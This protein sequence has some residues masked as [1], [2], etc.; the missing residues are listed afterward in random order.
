MKDITSLIQYFKGDELASKVWLDKYAL[1]DSN[2]NV[3]E[4]SPQQMH[5]R[6]AKEFARI[7]AKYGGKRAL[8]EDKILK[9]FNNFKYIIPGG[10]VMAVLGSSMIGSLSNCFVIGQPEDSYSGIM[11]LREEQAHLMKRRAGVGKDLSTLRPSGATVKNAA[12]TSTGAASFMDV[13]SA[14]TQEVAQRGR[15]GALMLTLDVRHPDI[16]D[17]IKKKQDL[18][19]VTGANISVKVTDDFMKAV[20]NDEDYILRWPLDQEKEI[21]EWI[22]QSNIQ[23]KSAPY[24]CLVEKHHKDNVRKTVTHVYLKKV[25]AKELWNLLIHCAWNTAEPGI[26]FSDKHIRFSPDGAYPQYRGVSTNPCFRGDMKLLTSTGYR[27]F[28]ELCDKPALL[29]VD[30]NGKTVPGK[31]WCSG[32]KQTIQLTLSNR[33]KIVCTPDHKFLSTT[34]EVLAKDSKGKRILAFS[35]F[36]DASTYL[37]SMVKA[38]F[39]QGDGNLTRLKSPIH[40]GLEVNIGKK[41][42]DIAALFGIEYNPIIRK[43]YI[44]DIVPKLKALQMSCQ[45]LPKR[46][47]PETYEDWTFLAKAS[48]LRGLWSANGSV[49]KS[50]RI[51][52]KTTCKE[53][54]LALQASL[55]EDFNMD[56][57]I[58]T[59]KCKQVTFKNGIYTCKESYDLNISRFESILQFAKEIGFVQKYKF[60]A[61]LNLLELRSPKVRKIESSD[62]CKVYDF[63]LDS[64]DHWG[65][66]E[67]VIAHNCGEIF[68]Q[69]Y[70]SCRLI[71]LNLT[72]CVQ[73]PFTTEAK[74]DLEKLREIAAAAIRLGDDLV[75]LEIEAIDKILAHIS[76]SPGDN[77]RELQLWLKI[78][79]NG[80]SSR[81]CGVGFTGLADTLAMLNTG[82]TPEGLSVVETIMSTIFEAE[83]IEDIHLA[84]ERGPFKGWDSNVENPD[85]EGNDWYKMVAEKYPELFSMMENSGR[86]NV[87][88][89]TVAPTGTVSILAQTS[90]GIEPVFALYYTRRKKCSE[91][92]TPDFVDQ[93]GEKFKEFKVFH[94]GFLDW[95]IKATQCEHCPEVAIAALQRASSDELQKIAKES[96][97]YGNTASEIDW[98]TRL[99]MQSIVQMYTTHSISSTLNLLTS[100]TEKQIDEI[101]KTAWEMN[102]KGVTVYRDGCRSG[103]LVTDTKPKTIFETHSAPKRPKILDAELHVVKV[104]KIKYAVIIGLLEG[105]P[106]ETFAFELGEGNFLPQHGKIIKVK[107][108]CYNFVGDSDLIIESIHLANDKIEER[109]SSIYISMLLRHGAPIEYVIATAK[110]VNENIASF[111]SAVCRVLMKYCTKNIEEE[112]CPECGAKLLREAG[113]KKCNNCGYSVCLTLFIR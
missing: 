100:T 103:V 72:S 78:K 13:D 52:L 48:F 91:E 62:V 111:T 15:R 9:Y 70:D 54:A 39:I 40:K 43:Y 92:E 107:R 45:V 33:K 47:L 67:G 20:L 36:R 110:K 51:A 98:K 28:E 101:Y 60:E 53:L 74:L 113:C 5:I 77:T 6:M 83:L 2:N 95:Y 86:R 82:F 73:N 1:R 46:S 66:V 4:E 19:K 55:L 35:P 99:K 93:N 21:N 104:K 17:F 29:L 89:S 109:A 90:S 76:S 69:P 57:Y 12:K 68:M 105:K 79:E 85:N 80:L 102:L 16:E 96:P 42:E 27:T 112:T 94:Q 38:G 32:I 108:G 41:D 58:T 65:V 14:L 56:S 25:R 22:V 75:D 26:M 44:T 11:K 81:R 50:D 3:L 88:F 97:Y 34:G 63:Q 59:N 7:E 24:N 30:R 87:S 10:S 71:H 31:V 23:A 18:S 84:E 49:I 106:Y 37:N 8:T 61:L 64:P